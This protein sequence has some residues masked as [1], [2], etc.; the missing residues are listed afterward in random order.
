MT[1]KK[2][3]LA[4]IVELVEIYD[5]KHVPRKAAALSYCLM[6]S[7]FPTLI[8]VHA[9]LVGMVPDLR[10]ALVDFEGVIPESA[11][12]VIIDYLNYVQLHNNPGLITAGALG[13]LTTSAAA[14]RTLHG[15]MADIQGE[16]R[17]KGI[18]GLAF[19]FLFSLLFLGAIY[20]GGLVMV[21]GNWIMTRLANAIP[22][23][24][25]ISIWQAVKYPVLLVIFMFIIYALYRIT[26][27]KGVRTKVFPGAILASVLIVIVSFFFSNI[28]NVSSRYPLL[29][30]SL[31]SII[32]FMLWLY[33]CGL[34]LIMC[35][36]MNFVL[37]KD[38]IPEDRGERTEDRGL[39]RADT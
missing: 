13:M 19:S 24:R 3:L 2:K 6:L 29:Y 21:S 32:V 31:A 4:A 18:F 15:I 22:L 37:R 20:F 12:T 9:V 10:L 27:P 36:A 25:G 39:S 28:I 23:L 11:L 26:A 38:K 33:A 34:I 14:F 35:N 17:F 5:G 30:G 7:V 1:G 8:C 16:S